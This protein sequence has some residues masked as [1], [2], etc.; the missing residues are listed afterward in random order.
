MDNLDLY[1]RQYRKSNDRIWFEK[2]YNRFMPQLF[3]YCYYRTGSKQEAEDL[4]SELALRA[5][6]NLGRKKFNSRQ[7]FGWLYRVA[8]NLLID[9]YRKQGRSA[10]QSPPDKEQVSSE[11]SGLI[12]N[13]PYLSIELG[14]KN[15]KLFKAMS[16][17]TDLQREV[18][19]LKFIEDFDYKLISRITGKRQNTLRGIVFRALD[20]LKRYMQEYE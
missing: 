17:L 6:N 1:L 15:E 7:F 19:I 16:R 10:V 5:Y 8:R 4:C 18:V 20:G 12:D 11:N 9:Y 2:I 13:S 14:I 3:R